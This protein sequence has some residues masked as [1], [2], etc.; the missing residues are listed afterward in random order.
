MSEGR[1]W[2]FAH[3]LADIAGQVAICGV[4]EADHTKASGRTA[5]EVAGQAVERALADAGL[6]PTDVDGI[7]HVPSFADAFD[8]AA[9]RDYFGT[10]HDMWES[11]RGGGMVWAGT[12]P[13][14][15]AQ[16]LQDGKATCIV[17]SFAVAWATQRG[18]MVGGPG[19]SH[20]QELFKQNLEVPFGW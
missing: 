17:N 3:E 13:H 15:A 6:E 14:D 12:A 20:A 16:A 9:F 2:G 1:D 7:M 19:Q 8:A 10:S 4:G 11:D 5:T 18:S